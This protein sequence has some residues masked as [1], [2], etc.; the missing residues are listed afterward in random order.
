MIAPLLFLFSPSLSLIS[1]NN[2]SK[3][4]LAACV[5]AVVDV[6]DD[7]AQGRRRAGPSHT[8]LVHP[9]RP[10]SW[11]AFPSLT[12]VTLFQTRSFHTSRYTGGLKTE[13]EE[14]KGPAEVPPRPRYDNPTRHNYPAY[15]GARGTLYSLDYLPVS[16]VS[17]EDHAGDVYDMKRLT[18]HVPTAAELRKMYAAMPEPTQFATYE[19]YEA[20]LG[21]WKDTT[22]A[23]LAYAQRPTVAGRAL[24]R[25]RQGEVESDAAVPGDGANTEASAGEGATPAPREARTHD[26][27]D[28]ALVPPEPNPLFYEDYDQYELALQR[29][30]IECCR[31]MA[32]VVPH[33]SQLESFHSVKIRPAKTSLLGE[34][35]LDGGSGEAGD[36]EVDSA[37]HSLARKTNP[38]ARSCDE[39]APRALVTA[40]TGGQSVQYLRQRAKDAS[41][42]AL[43]RQCPRIIKTIWQ[44]VR[45]RSTS[46]RKCGTCAPSVTVDPA[47]VQLLAS[48]DTDVFSVKWAEY[49][50]NCDEYISKV[51]SK[52]EHVLYA[53]RLTT[54]QD[55]AEFS[56]ACPGFAEKMRIIDSENEAMLCKQGFSLNDIVHIIRTPTS[57]NS[58]TRLMNKPNPTS[59]GRKPYLSVVT[60]AITPDNWT[61]LIRLWENSND[62]F[63]LRKISWLLKSVLMETKCTVME[64]TLAE[65][66][67]E[68]CRDIYTLI[69]CVRDT[70]VAPRHVF[71]FFVDKFDLLRMALQSK[72]MGRVS[73][74]TLLEYERQIL[75]IFFVYYTRNLRKYM[76]GEIFDTMH[77]FIELKFLENPAIK[78]ENLL[79]QSMLGRES[80]LSMLFELTGHRS[81]TVSLIAFEALIQLI[82][83][84]NHNLQAHLRNKDTKFV[85]RTIALSKSKFSHTQLASRSLVQVL[86]RVNQWRELIVKY[87]EDGRKLLQEAMQPPCV[88][89]MR[90]IS[91]VYEMTIPAMGS[92]WEHINDCYNNVVTC[93][94][95]AI[96][97]KNDRISAMLASVLNTLCK[98]CW[99]QRLIEATELGVPES[100]M[101]NSLKVSYQTIFV[102]TGFVQQLSAGTTSNAISACA[103]LMSALCLL[104]RN[105][106]VLSLMEVRKF[107]VP[108]I[109][110][111]CKDGRH[112]QCNH[113]A[114][115]MFFEL[116]AYHNNVLE[117]LIAEKTLGSFTDLIAAN[118]AHSVVTIN[119]I[120]Y[121]GKL[122]TLVQSENERH[123]CSRNRRQDIKFVERDVK[124]FCQFFR[125][126]SCF[127][128]LHLIYT[129][130]DVSQAGAA[131]REVACIYNALCV[132]SECE[133]LY[134]FICKDEK[135]K[136]SLQ[137]VHKM[138]AD[139]LLLH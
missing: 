50:R 72:A 19:E 33:A 136:E 116:I 133:R 87:F 94:G 71:P 69:C 22:T 124:T 84:P 58:F 25:P 81:A 80:V 82:H 128:K 112:P 132:L 68:S 129:S 74:N 101:K 53:D 65:A 39:W 10:H 45:D 49:D 108:S 90:C 92:S 1:P 36:T 60:A 38:Y 107:I 131:F 89:F 86:F 99:K 120:H 57:L 27:W 137:E 73:P 83:S 113:M 78:Q 52:L 42:E 77:D 56:F 119:S 29:W 17:A 6:V 41:P 103:L 5:S 54:A 91:N 76:E 40:P 139:T 23:A 102:L 32:T 28:A 121:I 18:A 15:L 117:D 47:A 3:G 66:S 88:P 51:L 55:A 135:Y 109:L 26:P 35:T 24:S 8:A 114:W 70:D 4:W 59:P 63:I 127:I 13:V 104:L 48:K 100:T 9:H 125:D 106:R 46:F 115:K 44:V 31:T 61:A 14:Y 93:L 138:F 37:V 30:H 123:K 20:A 134:S 43:Q 110:S 67:V 130:R 96:N 7:G 64:K 126:H 111:W 16:A 11:F 75:Q 122:F 21:H 95:S 85:E 118:K 62:S 97:Y 12:F 105:D 2:G 34:Y 79:L 98:Q